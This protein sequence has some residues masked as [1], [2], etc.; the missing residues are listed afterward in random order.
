MANERQ[1]LDFVFNAKIDP[2]KKGLDLATKSVDKFGRALD[3]AFDIGETARAT[4]QPVSGVVKG[5]NTKGLDVS[6]FQKM[7]AGMVSH[8]PTVAKAARGLAGAVGGVL[9]LGFRGLHKTLG[10]GIDLWKDHFLR[11]EEFRKSAGL[12]RVEVQDFSADVLSATGK[13][14]IAL[15]KVTQT[16]FFLRT[17]LSRSSKELASLA[18]GMENFNNLTNTSTDTTQA[19]G[20]VLL[21]QLDVPDKV[22]Q[23]SLFG[24]RNVAR[25][26]GV[27]TDSLMGSVSGASD[28]IRSRG[29]ENA[30]ALTGQAAAISAAMQKQ[31]ASI[32]NVNEV[33]SALGDQTSGLANLY[34]V[35][36]DDLGD[37]TSRFN[38]LYQLTKSSNTVTA[39]MAEQSL[40]ERFGLSKEASQA[41][42][43]S[44]G[45]ITQFQAMFGKTLD[46]DLKTLEQQE[47]AML[48]PVDRLGRQWTKILT[49]L[50]KAANSVFGPGSVFFEAVSQMSDIVQGAVEGI[51]YIVGRKEAPTPT[52]KMLGMYKP[53]T[54]NSSVVRQLT[55]SVQKGE[56][57]SEQAHT[58]FTRYLQRKEQASATPDMGSLE[59]KLDKQ[60][61]ATMQVR[62]ELRGIRDDSYRPRGPTKDMA[63]SSAALV[64]SGG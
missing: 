56:L 63:R 13:Y 47:E 28:F 50:A 45:H 62:D 37:F 3:A 2:L 43:E 31:G 9:A 32:S 29:K 60:T 19:L 16:T 22:F 53:G 23:K 35:S 21:M 39:A 26:S 54:E 36:G 12:S 10:E 51:R 64:E 59:E 8:F 6:G 38:E 57:T 48:G 49:E 42:A 11:M 61:D 25:E 14:G 52:S 5:L 20:R 4:G 18:A 44:I 34:K 15:D 40:A 46:K 7:V 1:I 24:I 58:F 33:L 30:V 27:L 55:T 17:G 41:L